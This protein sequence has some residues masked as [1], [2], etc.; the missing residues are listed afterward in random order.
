[1]TR[2]KPILIVFGLLGGLLLL[3]LVAP[4][5]N[6][7]I[8]ADWSGWMESLQEHGAGE[9][10]R[11]SAISSAIAVMIMTVLGV[12]LGYLLARG[13]LPYT[14]FWLSLVF[15]PMVVPDLSRPRL[16]RVA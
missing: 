15:L 8:H 2:P 10:L 1:M 4:I 11:I 12:P 3:N 9:A 14:R 16:S 7:L 13:R 6:L 5:A